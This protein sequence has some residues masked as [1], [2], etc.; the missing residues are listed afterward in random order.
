MDTV[1]HHLDRRARKKA[2]TRQEILRAARGL[3][4]ERGYTSVTIADIA[5]T[6][7]VAV[8]TVFNHF[9]T[10]EELFF[11][12]RA[13][14]VEGIAAAVRDRAP[15]VPPLTALRA[16][17]V[18]TVHVYVR[19]ALE[20]PHREM[21]ALMEASPALAAY[22][23][24]LH[25]EAVCRL[26]AALE[27]AWTDE[28]PGPVSGEFACAI[29]LGAATTAEVWLAAVRALLMQQRA[30]LSDPERAAQIGAAVSVL[31]ARAL[32]RLEQGLIPPDG[33]S[34]VERFLASAPTTR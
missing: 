7:D 33:F 2:Q 25:H 28:Q 3:F 20:G 23:R 12:D 21:V 17:L 5:A 27:E 31:V 10:K 6:A 13:P 4:A 9:P 24:E 32:G 16:Y 19:A 8:Q 34:F 1:S 11:S 30:V 14:W 18:D 29:H 26:T 22:E 15:G